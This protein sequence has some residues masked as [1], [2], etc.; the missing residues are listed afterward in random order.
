MFMSHYATEVCKCPK[1]FRYICGAIEYHILM[2]A[3]TDLICQIEILSN[4]KGFVK[5]AKG[6]PFVGRVRL[7]SEMADS[8]DRRGLKRLD[9][10]VMGVQESV[11]LVPN[12]MRSELYF[13]K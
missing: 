6:N 11:F 9:F 3:Q 10:T 5:Y 8:T 1:L 4:A 2:S 12:C 13:Q 7:I